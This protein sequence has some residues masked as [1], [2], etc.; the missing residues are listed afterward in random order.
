[1]SVTAEAGREFDKLATHLT[2]PRDSSDTGEVN[3]V[4]SLSRD[5]RVNYFR[6]AEALCEAPKAKFSLSV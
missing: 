1:L 3:L 4:V 6:P 2:T 5:A